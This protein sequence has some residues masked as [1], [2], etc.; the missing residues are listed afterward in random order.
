MRSPNDVDFWRGFAL[1]MIFVD[2]I[3]GIVFENFTYHNFAVSDAAELFVFLAGWSLRLLVSS[4]NRPIGAWPL[5]L[6]LEGRALT[7]FFAQI[8]ITEI[9]LGITAAGALYF[10]NPLI[11]AWNNAAATF[12][13]PVE[14]HVGLVMLSYQLFYF[15]I[16][17]LYVVLMASAPLIVTIHR[18]IPGLLL[19]LSLCVYIAALTFGYNFPTWPLDD[20]WFFNPLA[21]QLVFV[22]GFLLA[23]KSGIG[24]W[25]RRNFGVLRLCAVPIV[26]AGVVTGYFRF[27][28]DPLSLP[29]PRLFLMFDKTFVSPARILHLL[30]IV[31]VFQGAFGMLHRLVPGVTGLLSML[32]RNSLQVFC[33]G[34]ILSLCG[35]LARFAFGAT[36]V[37]DVLVVL[38]GIVIMSTTAWLVEWRDR[39]GA[40]Q[41]AH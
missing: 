38:V 29:E 33:V 23:G 12:Q 22:L 8:V 18:R 21:W 34:S 36:I 25:A 27:A 24:E 4:R 41:S 15:D 32:G 14:T 20:R 37:C 30:A 10:D 40:A 6:R 19:P 1:V 31:L 7:I 16:L 17:P 26:I 2:H 13:S 5:F 9:A 11:L 39:Y 35:Q 28:P 3:P